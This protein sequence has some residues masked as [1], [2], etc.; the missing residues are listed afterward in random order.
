ML[1]IT[2]KLE[3]D[4][5]RRRTTHVHREIYLKIAHAYDER[6]RAHDDREAYY[7]RQ[8]AKLKELH[9]YE[10]PEE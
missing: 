4:G 7:Q 5:F 8:M 1:N 3:L 6:R 2:L 9:S 10:L